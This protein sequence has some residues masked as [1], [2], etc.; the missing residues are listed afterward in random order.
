MLWRVWSLQLKETP[1]GKCCKS[2]QNTAEVAEKTIEVENT[3][4]TRKKQRHCFWGD[5]NVTD[6]LW[7]TETK[8]YE[9]LH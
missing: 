3:T 9:G 4:H 7:L 1:A 6:Q 8:T 2:T 5:N